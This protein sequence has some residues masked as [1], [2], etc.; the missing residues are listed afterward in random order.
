[1]TKELRKRGKRHKKSSAENQTHAQQ[2]KVL[3]D[4]EGP[5][6]AT[7]V[8]KWEWADGMYSSTTLRYL[9]TT[10]GWLFSPSCCLSQENA[11]SISTLTSAT[12]ASGRS[13]SNQEAIWPLTS[14]KTIT[15]MSS[16]T[17]LVIYVALLMKFVPPDIFAKSSVN[18]GSWHFTPSQKSG[19]WKQMWSNSIK[20]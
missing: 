3:R 4:H 12:T 11:R 20:Y 18:M 8:S 13:H 7:E 19:K 17:L 1:M 15:V 2:H 5:V 16:M 14:G 6:W 9:F 10:Q